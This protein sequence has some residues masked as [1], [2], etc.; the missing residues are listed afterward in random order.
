MFSVRRDR[1][2]GGTPLGRPAVDE[3]LAPLAGQEP[4]D[5][6]RGRDRP[7]P[8]RLPDVSLISYDRAFPHTARIVVSAERPVAV[9][10]HGADAWLVTERGEC[11]GARTTRTAGRCL[12]SGWPTRP[13][14]A[15]ASCSTDE[16]ALDPALVLGRVLAADERPLRP[17]RS[18]C[19]TWRG[20]WCSFCAR[21][22]SSGS[23][24]ERTISAA[25]RGRPGVLRIVEGEAHY[26]DV[27]VP[28]R[29]VAG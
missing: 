27:S 15:T 21:D 26:V 25:A 1:G 12:G 6:G 19:A 7:P 2:D 14:P 13:C 5:G 10:R 3:A 20:S 4:A 24:P 16:A 28:E 17:G 23:A 22:R 18:S 29:P 8:E 9:L 11:S